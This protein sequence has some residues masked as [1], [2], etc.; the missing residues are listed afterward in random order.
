MKSFAQDL[1]LVILFEEDLISTTVKELLPECRSAI[2]SAD[3]IQNVTADVSRVK[4]IDSQGL[5][6][7]LSL[8]QA[9]EERNA[10]FKVEGASPTNARLFAFVNLKERFGVE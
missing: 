2:E 7:L 8:Y 3:D 6:F 9:S 4:M 10:S 5:N 1:A